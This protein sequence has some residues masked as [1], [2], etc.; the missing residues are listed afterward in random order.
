MTLKPKSPQVMLKRQVLTKAV[1]T[2]KFKSFLENEL[3]QNI[4]QFKE[5][6]TNAT[7]QLNSIDASNPMYANL[8]QEKQEA[9]AYVNSEEDQRKFIK[10]LEL[11]SLYSQ[12]PVDGFVNVSVGDDLYKKLGGVEIIVEDGIIQKITMNPSQFA[13]VTG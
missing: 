7:T 12:G 9:E 2:E 4:N 13:K 10:N 5:R 11:K 6:L 8:Q 1:V 3:T